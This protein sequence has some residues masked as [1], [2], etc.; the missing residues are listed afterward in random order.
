MPQAGAPPWHQVLPDLRAEG[1]GAPG[2]CPASSE[3]NPLLLANVPLW[4]CVSREKE[5]IVPN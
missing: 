1:R 5:M 4:C 3:P 2:L